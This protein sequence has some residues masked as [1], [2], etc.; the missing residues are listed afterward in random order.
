MNFEAVQKFQPLGLFVTHQFT[1]ISSSKIVPYFVT[2]FQQGRVETLFGNLELGK[3]R[4]LWAQ[5]PS[6]CE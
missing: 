3:A 4:G 2:E 6:P 5:G 1:P